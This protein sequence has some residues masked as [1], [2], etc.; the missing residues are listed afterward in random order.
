MCSR[1][2]RAVA[3]AHGVR[4]HRDAL[5]ALEVLEGRRL[6]EGEVELGG[7]ED[8]EDHE[9]AAAMA[10]QRDRVEHRAGI[11]VEVR[12]QHDQAAAMAGLAS[13]A[14][15]ARASVPCRLP[16]APVGPVE[17]VQERLAGACRR[18]H[19]VDDVL[20]ERDEPDAVALLARRGRRGTRRGSARS[21]AW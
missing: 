15:A 18:R 1:D 16:P 2:Q 17:R 4:D 19:E 3:L 11:L 14:A 10:E 13:L 5:A 7:V 8:V 9:V 6:V 12:D 21:R 20:V